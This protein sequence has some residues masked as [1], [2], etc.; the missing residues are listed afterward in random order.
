MATWPLISLYGQQMD[1]D[2]WLLVQH[3]DRNLEFQKYVLATLEKLL[4]SKDTST[5]NYAY[6]F[7][8]VAVAEKRP[9]QYGTQGHC[10]KNQAW[11]P[12]EIEDIANLDSRRASMGLEPQSKYQ[13]KAPSCNV[14]E[15][16]LA[17]RE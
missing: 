8:R 9:Q 13:A 5:R 1:S 15:P 10:S 12:F 7:D 11:E 17:R 6:L 2:A 16:K 4:L 3:A 14:I